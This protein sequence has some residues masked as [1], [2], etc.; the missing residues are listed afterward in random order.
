MN[1]LIEMFAIQSWG[2]VITALLLPPVPF[3]V[4]LLLG[5]MLLWRGRGLGWLCVILSLAGLWLT[6]CE[7]TGQVLA[8]TLKVP[9]A[10]SDAAISALLKDVQSKQGVSIAVLGAGTQP[11]APEYGM[12][13]LSPSSIE[14]LRYGMW[15]ARRTGAPIGFSG[16]IAWGRSN[17]ETPEATVAARIAEQEFGRKLQWIDVFAK[18][19]GE[20]ASRVVALLRKAGIKKVIVVTHGWH[21]A[22]ARQAFEAAA[23]GDIEVIAAPVGLRPNSQVGALRWL[24]SLGGAEAVRLAL[25]EWL[26][27]L[28]GT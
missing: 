5:A 12:A 22:R 17:D 9:S 25:R 15:L 21:M 27:A 18:D 16:G 23:K 20:S 28:S 1:S 11:Y 8:R 4:L 26:G 24:P 3:L 19:T 7:G 6:Q 14:R 10:L 2:P 13:N